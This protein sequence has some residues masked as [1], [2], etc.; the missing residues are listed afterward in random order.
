MLVIVIDELQEQRVMRQ[1]NNLLALVVSV[2]DKLLRSRSPKPV[3]ARK[4][5]VKN[6]DHIFVAWLLLKLGQK[7]SKGKRASVPSTQC[8]AE[9]RLPT[10]LSWVTNS[11]SLVSD[12]NLESGAWLSARVL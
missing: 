5:V 8:A 3:L 2:G 6:D 11:N 12:E 7:E 4:R 9:A 1:N 10:G